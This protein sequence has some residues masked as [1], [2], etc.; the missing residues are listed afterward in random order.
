MGFSMRVVH[1][2]R[3]R[4]R[5]HR[6]VGIGKT[7]RRILKQNTKQIWM[8]VALFTGYE[9]LCASLHFKALPSY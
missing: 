1:G 2:E 5:E 7:A 4:E 3:A 6:G 8:K 9:I